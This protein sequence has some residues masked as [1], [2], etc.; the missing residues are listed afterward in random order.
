MS[1]DEKALK[2]LD[3]LIESFDDWSEDTEGNEHY[4]PNHDWKKVKLLFLKTR[5]EARE[6][7]RFKIYDRVGFLRQ[8]LN[9]DRITDPKKTVTTKDIIHWLKEEI[10]I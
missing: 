4:C 6:E 3:K 10:N 2:K 5:Q 7:E 9:E 8:W 1:S